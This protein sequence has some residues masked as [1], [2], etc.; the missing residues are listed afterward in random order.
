MLDRIIQRLILTARVALTGRVSL[1]NRDGIPAITP[2]EVAKA[3]IF[4][5]LDKIAICRK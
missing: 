1:A 4:F 5:L 3:K 2:E